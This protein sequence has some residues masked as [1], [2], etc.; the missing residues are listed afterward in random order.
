MKR[1]L[2]F[3]IMLNKRFGG[4]QNLIDEFIARAEIIKNLIKADDEELEKFTKTLHEYLEKFEKIPENFDDFRIFVDEKFADLC[5]LQLKERKY[6]ALK[7]ELDKLKN[8]EPIIPWFKKMNLE[9][10]EKDFIESKIIEIE[11]KESFKMGRKFCKS[12]L[13]SKLQQLRFLNHQMN[14]KLDEL[15]TFHTCK[16]YETEGTSIQTMKFLQNSI[17]DY[18]IKTDE[19]TKVYDIKS[20]FYE[21]NIQKVSNEIR[22]FN[23]FQ[24]SEMKIFTQQQEE[25]LE[26]EA[27]KCSE[28]LIND[29][30]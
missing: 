5:K 15:L 29:D 25:V 19:M 2:N 30:E 4:L 3:K 10:A 20:E 23:E 12:S 24:D 9:K 8:F 21:L 13:E 22:N 7:V 26:Y 1:S 16:F 28:K 14:V 11:Q 17:D 27:R 18:K 6:L